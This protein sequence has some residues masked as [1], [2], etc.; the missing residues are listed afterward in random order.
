M[1]SNDSQAD[2]LAGWIVEATDAELIAGLIVM[3]EALSKR[4]DE[5]VDEE[6]ATVP[7]SSPTDDVR[8]AVTEETLL[9]DEA[10]KGALITLAREW[11]AE[12]PPSVDASDRAFQLG[13]VTIDSVGEWLEKEH[14]PDGETIP[15]STQDALQEYALRY[16]SAEQVGER[17]L[18]LV[19]A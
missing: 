1:T 5:D 7:W 19:S 3:A 4:T 10:L 9:A 14:Y 2:V 17:M 16:P 15:S 18:A 12:D 13:W 11:L 6:A 8:P